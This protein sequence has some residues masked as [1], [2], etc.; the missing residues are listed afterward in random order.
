[1]RRHVKAVQTCAWVKMQTVNAERR[2]RAS[3]GTD[4]PADWFKLAG[5]GDGHPN[6][7][8]QKTGSAGSCFN[9]S[10]DLFP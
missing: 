7:L 1:M 6:T 5:D 2:I 9:F 10:N 4:V 3:G 8:I